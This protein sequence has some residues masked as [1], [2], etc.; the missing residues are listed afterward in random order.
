METQGHWLPV[1]DRR[2]SDLFTVHEDAGRGRLGLD[3]EYRIVD[4]EQKFPHVLAL[5]DL[6]LLGHL[7]V[8]VPVEHQRKALVETHGHLGFTVRSCR[9]EPLIVH[10]DIHGC[11]RR[12]IRW[13]ATLCRED[14]RV[15]A[16]LF[17]AFAIDT[18]NHAVADRD[19]LI[20]LQFFDL[21]PRSAFF[22]LLDPELSGLAVP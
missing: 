6:Q 1:K 7:L 11:K 14:E 2:L 22:G 9:S 19:L 17:F 12:P 4:G 21:G 3:L 20:F 10:I 8:S 16:G 13:Q 5:F 15:A 18:A